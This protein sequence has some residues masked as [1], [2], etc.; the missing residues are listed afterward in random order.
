MP[1][2]RDN[3]LLTQWLLEQVDKLERLLLELQGDLKSLYGI[4]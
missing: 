1:F 4:L 3:L 2:N